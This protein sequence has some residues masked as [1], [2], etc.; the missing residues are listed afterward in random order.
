MYLQAS[1]Y[2]KQPDNELEVRQAN[3]RNFISLLI[4]EANPDINASVDKKYTQDPT[5]E[6]TYGKE[7]GCIITIN[8]IFYYFFMIIVV[9]I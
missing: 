4:A 5:K 2:K 9:F 7:G 3:V 6:R 8:I 1:T